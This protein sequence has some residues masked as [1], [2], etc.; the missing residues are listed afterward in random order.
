MEKTFDYIIIG[1]GSAGCVL[2][3]RLSADPSKT[4]LLVEAGGADTK[5]EIHI[6]AGYAKLHHS[7]VDWGSYWTEPQKYVLDRQIYLPRGKVL[8]GCSSTN[9]MAYVRGNKEDYNDWAKLGNAGW[10]Y[11][12]VL[13]YFKKSEKNEDFNDAYHSTEGELNVGFAKRFKTPFAE[14]FIESC[15]NAG[16][17]RNADY[18]GATQEGAGFFQFSIKNGKR[19]SAVTAFINP[20][21]ARKNLTILLNTFTNR[22]LIE[23][24][25]ATGIEIADKNGSIS[26]VKARKE[27]ILSA[28]AFASPQ[29]LMLSGIG[30][31]EKLKQHGID[32][33]KHL[34][35][36]GQNLQDHIFYPVSALATVQEG[37]NHHLKAHNQVIDLLNYLVNKKGILTTSPLEAVAF[38]SSSLSQD[39]VDYQFHFASLHIGNDYKANLYKI[40]TFPHT[41]GFTILPTLLRPKSRGFVDLRSANPRVM[42]IIQPNFLEAEDDRRVLIEAG[43]KA[44]EV[45]EGTPFA[46]LRKETICPPD[47]L[48]DEAILLH[49]Q[50]IMETVYHPVGT[51]KMGNDE[52]AVVDAALRV[53]GIEGLRVVDASIMPNIVSGNTNAPVYMIAEKAADMIISDK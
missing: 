9:A 13:P 14:A 30:D 52:A 18:N 4:V 36:V 2:A 27:V 42:P 35:G 44:I 17:K 33:K 3:N 11:E 40:D 12:D 45:I 29:L 23:N 10:S 34:V 37:Q 47:R 25:R 19:E 7:N 49:I 41:D 20:I 31:A 22:I 48:S 1:A 46:A 38:G 51:C 5:L 39:R 6:P 21:K 26:I 28:G 16:F 53:R 32:C 8:G 43:R 15:V 24:D 50:K